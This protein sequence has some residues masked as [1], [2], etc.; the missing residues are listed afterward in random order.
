MKRRRIYSLFLL[1]TLISA[2]YTALTTTNGV[3]AM[4]SYKTELEN[5]RDYTP[6]WLPNADQQ[7]VSY[8][9]DGGYLY[10]GALSYWRELELPTQVI[11]SAVAVDPFHTSTLYVGAA[12][13]LA[14]YLS[15]DSGLHWERI[16]F[17]SSHVGGVTDIAINGAERTLYVA[18]DTAGI[19][20]LRDVGSSMI[21]SGHTMVDEAVLEIVTDQVNAGLTFAR[22][23]WAVYQGLNN[24]QQWLPLDGLNTVPTGL[25]VANGTPATAYIGTTDRGL[26]QSTDGVHWSTM[27]DII[28]TEAGS[29]VQVSAVSVDPVQPNVLY[30]AMNY[31]FGGTNVHQSPVGIAMSVDGGA[32]WSML[33]EKRDVPV[34]SLLPV[35][36]ETGAVF[37]LTTQSRTPMAFGNAVDLPITAVAV[38][39]ATSN[40]FTSAPV[41]IWPVTFIAWLVAAVAA[42]LL[43]LFMYQEWQQPNLMPAHATLLAR[44]R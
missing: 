38:N 19:F 42:A 35:V 32:E 1:I 9:V 10:V 44:I 18:T 24:G 8:A 7:E 22:T 30:V 37:G 16:P 3:Q 17:D 31:L 36:G 15:R 23:Q 14:I 21:L 11:A 12:N 40:T 34:V 25:A 41:T 5:V 33:T 20:R 27:T 4:G 39:Q 13:E 6:V 2:I 26:L 29:R 28:P 43:T